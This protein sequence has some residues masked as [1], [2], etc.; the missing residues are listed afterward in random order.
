[1]TIVDTFTRQV[2]GCS[3]PGMASADLC[4]HLILF[5]DK[6]LGLRLLLSEIDQKASD[7]GR[8]RSIS[9][10]RFDPCPTIHVFL[11]RNCDILH[12]FTITA[13]SNRAS[14]GA[15]QKER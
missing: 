3:E 4:N 9:F 8:N 7:E 6:P 14:G 2:V 15:L 13:T 10:G 11:H 1:M 12:G 5:A